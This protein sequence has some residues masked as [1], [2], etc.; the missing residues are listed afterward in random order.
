[1]PLAAEIFLNNHMV[2]EINTNTW[3][4]QALVAAPATLISIN[5]TGIF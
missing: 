1:M 5:K 4:L 2:V 3:Q